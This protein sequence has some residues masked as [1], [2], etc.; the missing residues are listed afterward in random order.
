MQPALKTDKEAHQGQDR[1][2]KVGK[3]PG[4][5]S[6]AAESLFGMAQTPC[7]QG[8]GCH[9]RESQS[10]AK[11]EHYGDAES[12]PL[13]LQADQ[14]DGERRRTRQQTSR[15]SKK[16]DLRIGGCSACKSFLDPGGMG[17]FMRILIA[18]QIRFMRVTVA[19]LMFV[20]M[21][22]FMVM[23]MMMTSFGLDIPMGSPG[24]PE[25]KSDNE[26][27]GTQ[28]KVRFRAFGIP[29]AP[30]MEGETGQ[31][32]DHEA[33]RKSRAKSQDYGLKDRAP[34]G[35]DERGHHRLGMARFQAVQSSEEDGRGNIKPGM[36]GSLPG[37][38]LE[39]VHKR[40]MPPYPIEPRRNWSRLENLP[41]LGKWPLP[42]MF[43]DRRKNGLWRFV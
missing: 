37:Q 10:R 34:D 25:R 20:F 30:I 8:P 15:E 7:R 28:L 13:Q 41:I 26:G 16:S 39:A 31:E 32:P 9:E 18:G 19:M 21:M 6:Q 27:S 40:N 35:D 2:G 3:F 4:H 5:G 38:L 12:K 29:V 22:V 43:S 36:K 14:N 42:N 33:V 17:E 1:A 11:R 24:H 23:M